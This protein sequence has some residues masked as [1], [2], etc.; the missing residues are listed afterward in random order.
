MAPAFFLSTGQSSAKL[1]GN[2]PPKK[3][4]CRNLHKRA[5]SL[6]NTLHVHPKSFEDMTLSA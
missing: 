3:S 1:I 6:R 5:T 4:E 2:S